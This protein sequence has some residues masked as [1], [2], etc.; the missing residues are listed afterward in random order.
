MTFT[1]TADWGV[2]SLNADAF[3]A[4]DSLHLTHLGDR[5]VAQGM[6]R[7]LGPVLIG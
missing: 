7:L 4:S 5:A 1:V 6:A 3:V 2:S